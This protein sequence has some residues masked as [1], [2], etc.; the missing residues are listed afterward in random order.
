MISELFERRTQRDVLK[1]HAIYRRRLQDYAISFKK[2]SGYFEYCNDISSQSRE[3]IIK[4]N[5]SHEEQQIIG[6]YLREIGEIVE[7]IASRENEPVS[8]M[9]KDYKALTQAFRDEKIELL[10]AWSLK[11]GDDKEKICVELR[12]YRKGITLDY[13]AEMLSVLLKKDMCPELDGDEILSAEPELYFF[14]DE[15][16]F[17]AISGFAKAVKEGETVSGDNYSFFDI[18]QKK[19]IMMLSDGTGSGKQACASSNQVISMM[20]DMLEIGY[21]EEVAARLI[22]SFYL[23]KGDDEDHPTLDVCKINLVDGTCSCLKVGGVFT[24]IKHEMYVEKIFTSS[25][26]LGIFRNIDSFNKEMKLSDED[27]VIM[28][29]DGVMEAF[30]NGSDD[31]DIEDYIEEIG[32]V[33]AGEIAEQIL[34]HAIFLNKGRIT[35]DMTVLVTGVW[36]KKNT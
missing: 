7:N 3:K 23:A 4:F 1:Y 15:P 5:K 13:V 29:S 14:Y 16:K 20:E 31:Y 32:S 28:M 10:D 35:D 12:T 30:A 34:R 17:M 27:F 25:L 2:L 26:P 36:R 19:V 21:K 9:Y 24:F 18:N 8:F 33:N 11:D 22:N 6:D